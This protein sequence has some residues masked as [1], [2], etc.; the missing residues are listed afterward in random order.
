MKGIIMFN[1]TANA[2][3]L[4]D[5]RVRYAV[6]TKIGA[7]LMLFFSA[8]WC[9]LQWSLATEQRFMVEGLTRQ[10]LLLEATVC[11]V[12]AVGAFMYLAVSGMGWVITIVR[13]RR[14]TSAAARRPAIKS[15]VR[16]AG[17]LG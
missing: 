13:M 10:F 14:P 2:R 7:A 11:A 17:A 6:S 3:S 12:I 9:L 15:A 5:Q 8:A 1:N 16:H 4:A